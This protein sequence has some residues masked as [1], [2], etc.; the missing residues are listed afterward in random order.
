MQQT[1]AAFPRVRWDAAVRQS[2][3]GAKFHYFQLL[4]ISMGAFCAQRA[5]VPT[6]AREFMG[7]RGHLAS[8][9]LIPRYLPTNDGAA[10]ASSTSLGSYFVESNH[11]SKGSIPRLPTRGKHGVVP[12]APEFKGLSVTLAFV[13]TSH[14]PRADPFFMVRWPTIGILNESLLLLDPAMSGSSQSPICLA[15]ARPTV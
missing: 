12:S 14:G 7:L 6:R 3:M 2:A 11:W 5:C 1:E 13:S 15:R 4:I 9:L 8:C 10:L